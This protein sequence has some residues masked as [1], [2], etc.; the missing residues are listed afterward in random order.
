MANSKTYAQ[1]MRQA[2]QGKMNAA[3]K[4]YNAGHVDQTQPQSPDDKHGPGYSNLVAN[5]WRR[6]FCSN[7]TESAED[8][9]GFDHSQA[10]FKS[11]AKND[12]GYEDASASVAPAAQIKRKLK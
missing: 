2:F 7:G 12:W 1:Q 6:G 4:A 8:K 11:P 5:D 10:K 9:P 3:A